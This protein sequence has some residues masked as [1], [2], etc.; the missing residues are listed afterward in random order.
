MDLRDKVVLVTGG[1][2]GIGRS[3]ALAYARQGAR[4]G[5]GYARSADEAQQTARDVA[6]AGGEALAL[7]ADVA[8]ESQVKAMVARLVEQWGGVDVLINSAGTTVFADLTDLD[9]I[10]D[11]AWQRLFS[12]NVLGVWYACRA[13]APSLQ[14]RGGAIVTIASVAGFTGLGS[15]IPYSVTKGAAITLTKSLARALAPQVRVNAIAPGFVDTRWHAARPNAA[16]A[17]AE[18]VPLKR[19]AGPDDVADL[20]L[21]L[22]TT[23]VVTGQIMVIDA[24][25][26]L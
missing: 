24:G 14:E 23:A 20:A 12:V 25:M 26:T 11:A 2:T 16:Q 8:D 7:Q 18:R 10:T 19:V 5:I 4:V 21:Y 13:C 6:A 9:A 22:G 15:S 3:T 17:M 1:A